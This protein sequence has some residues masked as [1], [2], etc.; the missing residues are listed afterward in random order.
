MIVSGPRQAQVYASQV[1]P[2]PWSTGPA[3]QDYVNKDKDKR[4]S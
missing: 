4:A 1:Q 3:W 2:L